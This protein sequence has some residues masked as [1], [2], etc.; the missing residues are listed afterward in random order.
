[1]FER[2]RS[3]S[4]GAMPIEFKNPVVKQSGL[5]EQT[6]DTQTVSSDQEDTNKNECQ[7]DKIA[8]KPKRKKENSLINNTNKIQKNISEF[9]IPTQMK[10]F[11][12]RKPT[13]KKKFM[14]LNPSL[15]LLQASLTSQ[16]LGKY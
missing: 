10:P 1:M 2:T 15:H 6:L 13:N 8:A 9:V 7:R 5:I 12:L 14:F 11:V 16:A 4:L 3:N